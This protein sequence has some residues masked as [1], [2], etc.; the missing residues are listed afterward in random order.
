M[1]LKPWKLL[2][3]ELI[4][5]WNEYF[6]KNYYIIINQVLVHW[7]QVWKVFQEDVEKPYFNWMEKSGVWKHGESVEKAKENKG[8]MEMVVNSIL[9]KSWLLMLC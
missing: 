7:K 8:V 9:I 5:K 1:I 3:K 2:K 6:F 4:L